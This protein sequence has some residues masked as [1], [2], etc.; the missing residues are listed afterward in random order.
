MYELKSFNIFQTAKVIAVMYEIFFAIGAVFDFALFVHGG[1]RRPHLSGI[2]FMLIIPAVFGFISASI[3]CWLYNLVAPHTG[4][5][6]FELTPP[7]G[8]E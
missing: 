2:V 1:T 8:T 3:M 5:I 7:R 6:A 4:G